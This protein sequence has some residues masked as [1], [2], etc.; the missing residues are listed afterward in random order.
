MNSRIGQNSDYVEG[1]DVVRPR[2]IVYFYDNFQGDTSIE[3]LCDVIFI[4]LNGHFN[5]SDMTYITPSGMSV[6][7]YMCL[8]LKKW[9]PYQNFKCVSIS[10]LVNEIN[11]VPDKIHI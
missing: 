5:D 9:N 4:I 3:F 8:L 11:Y 6:V 10:D 7:D 1:V 2:N